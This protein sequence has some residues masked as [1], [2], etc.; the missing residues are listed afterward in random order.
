M[1]LIA[2]ALVLALQSLASET[3]DTFDPRTVEVEFAEPV[4][5]PPKACAGELITQVQ[6]QDCI[7]GSQLGTLSH[8]RAQ[9]QMGVLAY[10]AGYHEEAAWHFADSYV[11]DRPGL[12]FDPDGLSKRSYTYF[13]VG[14]SE[15]ALED[16]LLLLRFMALPEA[17]VRRRGGDALVYSQ[18]VQSDWLAALIPVLMDTGAPELESVVELFLAMPVNGWE[19]TL[20]RGAVLLQLGRYEAALPYIEEVLELQPDL[21]HVLANHCSVTRFLGRPEDGLASCRRAVEMAPQM[22]LTH[23]SL[24]QSLAAHGLCGEA[25]RVTVAARAR[26][27]NS[28]EFRQPSPCEA[29]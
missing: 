6:L 20:N 2:A 24:E 21:P 5:E 7:N 11:I 3:A 18:A 26:F 13:L 27:P 22:A 29:G 8:A 14:L 10:N 12:V 4:A 28:P 9:F 15:P 16:G 1:T 17:E 25:L 23:R 19:G